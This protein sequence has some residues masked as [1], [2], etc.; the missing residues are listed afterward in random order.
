[1]STLIVL[2]ATAWAG[3]PET[4][5]VGELYGSRAG[6]SGNAHT[7]PKGMAAL[8]PFNR[9]AVGL[10]DQVDLKFGIL[11]QALGPEAGAEVQLLGRE[12]SDV[13]LSLETYNTVNGWGFQSFTTLNHVHL[14]VPASESVLIT[15]SMMGGYGPSVSVA[16]GSG[17]FVDTVLLQPELTIDAKVS[18]RVNFTG[19]ARTAIHGWQAEVPNGVLGGIVAYGSGAIGFS[20][21]LNL[22]YGGL[23]GPLPIGNEDAEATFE[24]DLVVV[25][26]PHAQVWF[27]L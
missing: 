27:R 13:S 23:Q 14:T 16:D 9:S 15:V 21:G 3:A 20:A 18:D 4:L 1:M 6:W 22:L 8:R 5:D 7:V 12:R 2:M 25:P 10:T 19:T 26:L 24:S 11:G 17:E